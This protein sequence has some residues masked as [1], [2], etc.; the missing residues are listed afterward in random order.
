MKL[1]E[2]ARRRF[3]AGVRAIFAGDADFARR[4]AVLY[5]LFGMRWCMILLNEYQPDRRTG[6]AFARGRQLEKARGLLDRLHR[7]DEGFPDGP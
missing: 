6:R 3:A 1:D 2:A 5:P 4:C 7:L